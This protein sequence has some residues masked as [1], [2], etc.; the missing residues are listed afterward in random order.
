[1]QPIATTHTQKNFVTE[2]HPLAKLL[3][4][5]WGSSVKLGK[6]QRR[7]AWPVR[8]D[9]THQSRSGKLFSTDAHEMQIGQPYGVSDGPRASGEV[10]ETCRDTLKV[11]K[12]SPFCRG[13]RLD[14]V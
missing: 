7:L 6:T 10:A 1:M 13:T 4:S 2:N 11:E 9:D 8:K 3:D 5:F 14:Q 12:W